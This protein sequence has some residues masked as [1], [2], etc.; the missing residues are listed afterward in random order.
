VTKIE[1]E[2][3]VFSVKKKPELGNHSWRLKDGSDESWSEV[4]LK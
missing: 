2:K 1:K 4:G 3:N